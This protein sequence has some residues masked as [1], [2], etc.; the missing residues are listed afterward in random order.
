MSQTLGFD[1]EAIRSDLPVTRRVAYLNTGTAGPL[2]GVTAAAMEE[3]AAA[4]LSEGRIG[5]ESFHG[6][7]ERLSGLRES[8]AG[9]LG[10]DPDEIA[11]TH[12]TTEGMNIGLW[13]I[14]WRPGDEIVTTT[15]EH[16]GGLLPIYLLH[17]RQGVKVTFVDCGHGGYEATLEAMRRA[18]HPGVRMVVL[19]HVTYQTGAILPLRE[20]ADLAHEAGAAVLV[21]GAQSVGAIPVS[22]HEQGADFYAFPGQKWLCGPE[23]TG[24]LYVR[25]ERLAELQQTYIG[26]FGVEF[27][28]FRADR[29]GFEPAEGARRYEVG[30]LYRPGIVGLATSLSWV[31]AAGPI[32]PAIAELS[33]YCQERVRELPGAEVLTP[34]SE[35][36]SG[37][38]TVRLPDVDVEACLAFLAGRGVLIRSIPENGAFRIS[39]GF[40]NTRQ[41]IDRAVALL[42]EFS[43]G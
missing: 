1:V 21:D 28:S 20:I 10:A 26:G 13:G 32:F 38:V 33:R 23:G 35:Q 8:L 19:S 9:F 15:L 27:H 39:C 37:L 42:R 34:A 30:S 40:Y 41:E 18:L 31:G 25:R 14:D 6:F 22:M 12:H 29:V 43:H 7:F 2:P 3:A 5:M 17:R 4:E 24:G 36:P 11:L 16:G